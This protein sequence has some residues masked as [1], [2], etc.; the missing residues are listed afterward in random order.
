MVVANGLTHMSIV[1]GRGEGGVR[2]R[3]K[4]PISDQ[5]EKCAYP[6]YQN[7]LHCGMAVNV[8]SESHW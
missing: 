2:D 4:D 7:M 8:K 5:P 1:I 6:V 3:H